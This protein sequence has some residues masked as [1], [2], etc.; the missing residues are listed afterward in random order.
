MTGHFL[1]IKA[2][3]GLY[4][5]PHV[6]E[7]PEKNFYLKIL[8]IYRLHFLGDKEKIDKNV[9]LNQ[10]WSSKNDSQRHFWAV[11]SK[12]YSLPLWA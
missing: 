11:L 2:R 8:L 4:L 9:V 6:N 5:V 3:G 1:L 12:I 7:K 10:N